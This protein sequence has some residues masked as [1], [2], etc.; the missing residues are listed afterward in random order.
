[1]SYT[2]DLFYNFDINAE[3]QRYRHIHSSHFNLQESC[4]TMRIGADLIVFGSQPIDSSAS[5]TPAAKIKDNRERVSESAGER[6]RE[7]ERGRER[8]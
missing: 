6:E 3:K 8:K 7:R 4:W 2:T 5:K 1:M